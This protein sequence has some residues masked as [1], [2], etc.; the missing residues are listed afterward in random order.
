[1]KAKASDPARRLAGTKAALKAAAGRGKEGP[2]A[3][4]DG[5]F[6][7]LGVIAHDLNNVFSAILMAVQLLRQ[8]AGDEREA[9]LLA[10]LEEHAARG[11]ELVKKVRALGESCAEPRRRKS[12]RAWRGK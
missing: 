1:M 7:K 8:K 6:E 10:V 12:P 4:P 11:A 2:P 3:L 5:R 9:R